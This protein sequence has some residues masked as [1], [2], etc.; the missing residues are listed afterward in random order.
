MESDSFEGGTRS[1]IEDTDIS[2]R[3][4]P[5]RFETGLTVVCLVLF[6]KGYKALCV[7]L[8]FGK[9]SE[10]HSFAIAARASRPN[11]LLHRALEDLEF[12]LRKII[13]SYYC[14]QTTNVVL[15]LSTIAD[16]LVYPM[17]APVLGG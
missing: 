14:A 17:S 1:E 5:I 11:C 16:S 7:P 6:V 12:T 3:R 13:I 10:D 15:A 9:V 2:Q 8:G 4:R